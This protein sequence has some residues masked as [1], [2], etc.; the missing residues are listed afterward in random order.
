MNV[1]IARID[2]DRDNPRM[3]VPNASTVSAVSAGKAQIGAVRSKQ[4]YDENRIGVD[5]IEPGLLDAFRQNPYAQSLHSW[6][7]F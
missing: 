7:N 5:R 4:Q 2:S 1:N 6:V 3:W